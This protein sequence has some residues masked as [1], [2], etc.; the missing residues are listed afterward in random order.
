MKSCRQGAQQ[1]PKGAVGTQEVAD[2]PSACAR[3]S[4]AHLPPRLV[5]GPGNFCVL[6]YITRVP[7]QFSV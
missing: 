2:I 4:A 5:Q 6:N 1:D 3:V 7:K